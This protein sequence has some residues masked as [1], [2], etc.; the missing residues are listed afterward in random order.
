MK[1]SGAWHH[2]TPSRRDRGDSDVCGGSGGVVLAWWRNVPYVIEAIYTC[3]TSDVGLVA[4]FDVDSELWKSGVR[5]WHCRQHGLFEGDAL[6]ND[7]VQTWLLQ[8]AESSECGLLFCPP[9][10]PRDWARPIR[11]QLRQADR[12]SV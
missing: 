1:L 12:H 10:Y 3:T 11:H 6:G 7:M 4:Q 9:S 5:L 2:L 8:I